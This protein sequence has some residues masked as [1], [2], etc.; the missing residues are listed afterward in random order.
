[1][2]M[3]CWEFEPQNRP[4]FQELH[5]N[6]TNYIERIA[7]YLEVTYNPFKGARGNRVQG[8]EDKKEEE[9]VKSMPDPGIA[10]EVHPPL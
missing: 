7:G 4:S 1:M 6:T 9:D 3:K 8:K 2:M 5:K 10:I